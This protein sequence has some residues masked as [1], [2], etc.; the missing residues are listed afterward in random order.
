M[1]GRKT[2]EPMEVLAVM[3]P[4]ISPWRRANQRLTTAAASTPAT[5]PLPT[6]VTSPQVS[7]YCQG[8]RISRLAKVAAAISARPPSSTRRRPQVCI[9]AAAKGLTKPLTRIPSPTPA[10]TVERSQPNDSC[11]GVSST[12]GAERSPAA[13]SRAR[14]VTPRT[15]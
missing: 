12:P 15:T 1:V 6:P 13:A 9:R 7:R 14:K 4:I 11:S 8:S 3:T 2:S 5:A 10:D